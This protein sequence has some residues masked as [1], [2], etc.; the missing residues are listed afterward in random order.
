M[1]IFIFM[2]VLIIVASVF[3]VWM[4]EKAKK[5]SGREIDEKIASL[6]DFVQSSTV[7]GVNNTYAFLVDNVHK[8]VAYISPLY[9][10]IIPYDQIISV[11]LLEEGKTISKKSTMRTIGGALVGGAIGGGAGAIIGGLSGGRT[12]SKKVSLVQVKIRL[13]DVNSPSFTITTFNA[14]TMTVEGKP[15]TESSS[16][17]YI[18]RNGRSDANRIVDLVSIIIDEID[19]KT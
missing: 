3:Q 6:K 4:K 19:K 8:K 18:Y 15:I 12:E 10:R 2:V 7:K 5:K 13:R 17:G 14:R 11:D 9:K 1:G 16:E